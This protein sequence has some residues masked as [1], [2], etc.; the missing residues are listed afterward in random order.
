MWCVVGRWLVSRYLVLLFVSSGSI[1]SMEW[2]VH[3]HVQCCNL[4]LKTKKEDECMRNK[5][6]YLDINML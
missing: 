2:E 3:V 6:S 5:I 1:S 4:K